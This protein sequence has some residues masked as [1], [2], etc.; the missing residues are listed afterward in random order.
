[1]TEPEPKSFT[2]RPRIQ[3]LS[4][5]V[6]GLTLTLGAF[7]IATQ[8]PATPNDVAAAII[9]YGFSFLVIVSVWR[10]YST[11]MS[12]LP[13]ET[14]LLTDLNV[15]LLFI[16]S[17]EPYLFQQ[18]LI[19][20]DED[21]N[22]VSSFFSVDL[23]LMFVILAIFSNALASEEKRLVPDRFLLKFKIDRAFQA[24]TAAVIFLTLLPPFFSPWYITVVIGGSARGVPLRAMI[25][26]LA[27]PFNALRVPT[28]HFIRH[29]R[30]RAVA[31]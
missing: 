3:T 19:F 29:R 14:G 10:N 28:Q 11:I 9:E 16:V 20:L 13:T 25:W 8:K 22:V 24:V 7:S 17:I 31:K 23:G 26:I 15:L 6:F 2:P 4:D 30:G 5:L 21:W 1:M 12:V 27:L 18:L